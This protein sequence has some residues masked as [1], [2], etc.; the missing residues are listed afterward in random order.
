MAI[1]PVGGRVCL[2]EVVPWRWVLEGYSPTPLTPFNLLHFLVHDA[3]RKL[4][5]IRC[6]LLH[7]DG[8]KASE[9]VSQSQPDLLR[10][11][12]VRY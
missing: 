2:A 3:V 4:Q 1:D 12:S 10:L 7:Q 11:I 9:K 8:M 5:H 6:H